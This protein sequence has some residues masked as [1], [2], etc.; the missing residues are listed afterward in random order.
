MFDQASHNCFHC[1]FGRGCK[2]MKV[3]LQGLGAQSTNLG[4]CSICI[5][6]VL[7]RAQSTMDRAG[8]LR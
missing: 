8:S 5:Y 1:H 6:D 3:P 2:G 7:C 4:D